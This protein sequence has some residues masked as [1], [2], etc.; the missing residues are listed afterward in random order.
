M[1]RIRK[2]R[3]IKAS[4]RMS[5]EKLLENAEVLAEHPEKL[6]PVCSNE[7]TLCI[8]AGLKEKLKAVSAVSDSKSK[9]KWK[10]LFGNKFVKAYAGFLTIRF[11]DSLAVL[12]A[13]KLPFGTYSFAM[14]GSAPKELQLAVQHFDEPMCKAL[15][16][17]GFAKKGYFFLV[18]DDVYCMGRELKIPEAFKKRL[19]KELGYKLVEK[20]GT[21]T[22]GH[23]TPALVVRLK[24]TDFAVRV[25]GRCASGEINLLSR[26]TER[27]LG[28]NI[29]RLFRVA[30]APSYAC[31]SRCRDCILKEFYDEEVEKNYKVGRRSDATTLQDYAKRFEEGLRRGGR[32]V[33]VVGDKCFGADAE[34]FATEIASNEEEKKILL[35]AL[36]GTGGAV[37]LKEAS[38]GKF[39]EAIWT[40]RGKDI[41]A[42]VS[43][44]EI[45]E[46]LYDEEA[47]N[48]VE[49]LRKAK[50]EFERAK[51]LKLLPEF[52]KLPPLAKFIHEIAV[53]YLVSGKGAA[54]SAITGRKLED[55][56]MR[57]VA[58][59]FLVNFGVENAH[60][61]QFSNE[62]KELGKSLGG[63]VSELLASRGE[64]YRQAL[65]KILKFSG[66]GEEAV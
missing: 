47:K 39:L 57:T 63:Y 13:V 25:C 9:L 29:D 32:Q 53:E 38:F 64:N 15:A 17:L 23:D 52:R 10:M 34:K 49:I 27:I 42:L 22:C 41:L 30:F 24:N 62:E 11:S 60:S 54:V 59:A 19:L 46:R 21:L 56:K 7:C 37:V 6:L 1:G 31:R 4:S 44:G 50:H 26:L 40:E 61:W 51:V 55:T 28:R 36:E 3:G 18:A 45:A 66:S 14:R 48:P 58:F 12:A 35:K 2:A 20:E 8:L 33:Y 65:N 5:R 43:S 16:Y